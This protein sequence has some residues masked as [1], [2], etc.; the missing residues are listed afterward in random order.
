MTWFPHVTVATVVEKDAR[1][2]MVREKCFGD[3]V[4]NQPAGHLDPEESL[5][6]AAVRETLEE[7][8]W[9]VE[10]QYLIGVQHYHSAQSGI[11]YIRFSFCATALKHHPDR[12]LDSAILSAEWKS[13]NEIK[14]MPE[15]L[16]SPMVL[17][18]IERYLA[19]EKY[20]LSLINT[21]AY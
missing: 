16:R 20:P 4:Y 10:V 12:E 11:T 7:T 15:L 5:I 17:Q 2:L 9:E 19:G 18:D 21:L 6:D 14:A 8:A 1:F 13:F 3:I